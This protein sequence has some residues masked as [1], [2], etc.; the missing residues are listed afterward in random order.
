MA[1][2]SDVE[3][4]LVTAA[5]EA[6]YPQGLGQPSCV[7]S[8]VRVFRGEPIT[9]A[10][11]RDLAANVANVSVF[12]APETTRNTTRWSSA[13][14]TTPGTPTL[15][16]ETSG[17]S[18]SFSGNAGVGQVCGIIVDGQAFVHRCSVNDT[19]ALVAAVLAAAI[20]VYRSCSLSGSALTIPGAYR[21][22]GRI[23]ADGYSN[24]EVSRQEQGFCIGSWCPTPGLRDRV[25]GIIQSWLCAIRFLSLLDG[26]CGRL[27]YRATSSFDTYQAFQLY[28]RDL[29]FDVEYGT[30][31]T[32][33]APTM[34]FGD[35]NWTGTTVFV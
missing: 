15:M 34:L 3:A 31:I 7:G 21:L 26:T 10:L 29:V 11:E 13:P 6:L 22:V 27:R 35:L 14:R 9:A 24:T 8:P 4:A 18:L 30:T 1:D 23:V 12:S 28:R 20:G 2:L 5:L 19:P 25:A 32:E 16:V 33:A 17:A